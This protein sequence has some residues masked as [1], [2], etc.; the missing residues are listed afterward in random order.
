MHSLPLCKNTDP[1]VGRGQF[2]GNRRWRVQFRQPWGSPLASECNPVAAGVMK[3]G[4]LGE[5]FAA[6]YFIRGVS[7]LFPNCKFFIIRHT[8]IGN[9]PRLHPNAVCSYHHQKGFW[10]SIVSPKVDV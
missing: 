8:L 5:T 3:E 2:R 10:R 4:S 1:R 9:S 6:P 7:P